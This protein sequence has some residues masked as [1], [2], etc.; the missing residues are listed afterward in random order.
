MGTRFVAAGAAAGRLRALARRA[1]GR[2]ASEWFSAVGAGR[3]DAGRRLRR[4][5][6]GADAASAPAW[7]WPS[8]PSC[9]RWWRWR[10]W[11]YG[12][13]PAAA[14]DRRHRARPRS[15]CLLLTQGQG[16]A[17]FAGGP[18]GASAWPARPGRWAAVWALHGLPGGR[19]LN[20]PRRRRLRQPDAGWRRD[21]AGAV[22]A[23]RRAAGAGRPTRRALA[24][25][26]LP[27]RRR[28]AGRLHRLHA[29]A[30]AHQRRRWRRATP[31][32]TR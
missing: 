15:A 20:W 9:R 31:S 16:F 12:V 17:R 27:R 6:G 14:G 18:A 30:A 21:A 26:G 32:S 1:P 23:D 22:V 2:R 28:L 19:R 13:R 11:P 24:S 7:W 8:S 25:L 29:A 10:S 5:G 4:H 3:A